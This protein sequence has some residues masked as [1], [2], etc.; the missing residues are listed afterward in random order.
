MMSGLTA[1]QTSG[2][3]MSTIHRRSLFLA[4]R[5]IALMV[6]GLGIGQI[7]ATGVIQ[8]RDDLRSGEDGHVMLGCL[9]LGAVAGAWVELFLRLLASP[10][11]QYSVA[12]M[13]GAMTLAAATLAGSVMLH[14]CLVSS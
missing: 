10:K 4:C 11:L 1:L 7:A 9:Y 6:F 5:L 2:T 14:Q 13:L 8:F 3:S 12:Q